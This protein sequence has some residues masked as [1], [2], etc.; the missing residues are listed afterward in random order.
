MRARRDPRRPDPMRPVPPCGPPGGGAYRLSRPILP[1]VPRGTRPRPA[2]ACRPPC[3]RHRWREMRANSIG[4]ADR[5]C[6]LPDSRLAVGRPKDDIG[7]PWSPD[8]PL[9]NVETWPLGEGFREHPCLVREG[10]RYET[11]RARARGNEEQLRINQR[12]TLQCE[13]GRMMVAGV[14]HICRPEDRAYSLGA[15][16][17]ASERQIANYE[18]RYVAKRRRHSTALTRRVGK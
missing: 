16:L 5:G 15:R 9:P 18:R 3:H 7:G 1:V 17:S 11:Y 4:F 13:C 14:D 6:R 2:T 10:Y 8:P 12:E